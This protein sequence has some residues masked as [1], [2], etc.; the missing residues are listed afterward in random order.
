LYPGQEQAG[1]RPQSHIPYIF[2]V[3]LGVAGYTTIS[4]LQSQVDL[5][6]LEDK[7]DYKGGLRP[8]FKALSPNTK[9]KQKYRCM[10]GSGSQ[11][12]PFLFLCLWNLKVL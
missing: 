6:K 12:C 11:N 5:C 4:T 10:K 7:M 9:Q 1:I 8:A 3:K 2:I